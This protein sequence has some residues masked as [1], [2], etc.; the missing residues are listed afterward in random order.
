MVLIGTKRR[1]CRNCENTNEGDTL[2]QCPECGKI[3]CEECGESWIPG[4]IYCPT[5]DSHCS[6]FMGFID[7]DA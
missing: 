5:C 2:Y 6:N 7:P 3:T 1:S 4:F